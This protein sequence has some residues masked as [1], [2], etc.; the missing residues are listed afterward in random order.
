MI[1]DQ[2][3]DVV[4]ID[5]QRLGFDLDA[6]KDDETL[7]AVVMD[8]GVKAQAG[9]QGVEVSFAVGYDEDIGGLCDGFE[10]KA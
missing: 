8:D 1:D 9:A 2:L 3:Q 4:V 5:R 10:G 6:V 7:L